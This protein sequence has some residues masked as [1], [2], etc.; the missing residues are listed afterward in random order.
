MLLLRVNWCR[1]FLEGNFAE[2]LKIKNFFKNA[3]TL[4]LDNSGSRNPFPRNNNSGGYLD[5][6]Y[7]MSGTVLHIF[8]LSQLIL[9]THEGD[10]IF[11]ITVQLRY[12]SHTIQFAHLKCTT[13]VFSIFIELCNHHHNFRTF[14]SPPKE[15]LIGSP[16][17]LPQ[18]FNPLATTNLLSVSM[19]LP[20]LDIS[21]K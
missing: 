9:T 5:R 4:W 8:M 21:Y 13:Q 19:D 12:N 15:T 10:T 1:L 7:R 3:P 20:I 6:A 11:F 2:S 17:S 18:A 16:S 14:S